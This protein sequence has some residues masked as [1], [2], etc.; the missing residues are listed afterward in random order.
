MG[1]AINPIYFT[2][3]ISPFQTPL[4]PKVISG[5]VIMMHQQLHVIRYTAHMPRTQAAHKVE[6]AQKEKS[7]VAAQIEATLTISLP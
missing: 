7:A 2:F 5:S 3:Y 1:I 6:Y 4:K